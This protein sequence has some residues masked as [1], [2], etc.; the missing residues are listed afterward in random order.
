MNLIYECTY[1]AELDAKRLI[2]GPGPLGVRVVST[3]IGGWCKGERLSGT[4]S[5]AAGDWMLVGQDGFG[6]LDVR[7]Q[8]VTQDGAVVLVTYSGLIEMNQKVKTAAG[9][10]TEFEDQYFRTLVRMESGA[11]N[12][13][14]VNTTLFV[15]RGRVAPGG[16]EYEIYRL[17]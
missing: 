4:L 2:V 6:R 17:T 15:G 16:V 13:A 8:L 9:G 3:V 10:Q 7:G 12:Y 14:W 5:G 1:K 11:P